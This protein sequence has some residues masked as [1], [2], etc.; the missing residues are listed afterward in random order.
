MLHGQ[1]LAEAIRGVQTCLRS[2]ESAR[3]HAFGEAKGVVVCPARRLAPIDD[4][5]R[6][7]DRGPPTAVNSSDAVD[8]GARDRVVHQARCV[9]QVRRCV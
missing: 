1:S 2:Q 8:A 9:A 5:W 4:F 6:M 7:Q 3:V